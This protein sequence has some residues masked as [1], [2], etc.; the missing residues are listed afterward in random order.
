MTQP[1][2][3]TVRELLA[4]L[5]QADA[6]S[7]RWRERLTQLAEIC[8]LSDLA[9]WVYRRHGPFTGGNAHQLADAL[10]RALNL[11]PTIV[12]VESVDE[13]LRQLGARLQRDEEREESQE[14]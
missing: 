3:R 9:H 6:T 2:I 8:R 5:D 10:D 4:S 1:P 11:A 12:D 14:G 13:S 7:R